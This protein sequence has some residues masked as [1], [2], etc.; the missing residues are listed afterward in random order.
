MTDRPYLPTVAPPNHQPVTCSDKAQGGPTLIE[1]VF[2]LSLCLL[3]SFRFTGLLAI[4]GLGVVFLRT[5]RAVPRYVA[6]A[7]TTLI[8]V[9]PVDLRFAQSNGH[10]GTATRFAS[11]VRAFPAGHTAH[12]SIRKRHAEYYTSG[13]LNRPTWILSLDYSKL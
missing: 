6:L 5:T 8:F 10:H 1:L 13:V 7:L 11:I 4:I 3:L 2:I 12:S 9:A